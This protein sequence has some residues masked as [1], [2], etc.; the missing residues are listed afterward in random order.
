MGKK[1][2]YPSSSSHLQ[3]EAQRPSPSNER[4]SDPVRQDPRTGVHGEKMQH[5]SRAVYGNQHAFFDLEKQPSAVATTSKKP[6]SRAEALDI[7]QKD[8]VTKASIEKIQSLSK[9][10]YGSR[11]A[12]QAELEKIIKNPAR[13]ERILET[14]I[15]NP[16]SSHRM[17]GF[18]FRNFRTKAR[19]QAVQI[20]PHLCSAINVY[21]GNVKYLYDDMGV[22]FPME[23]SMEERRQRELFGVKKQKPPLSPERITC[24]AQ[25]DE[26]VKRYHTRVEH[27][28]NIVYGNP[29]A[30]QRQ[31]E[32][33][34]RNPTLGEQIAQIIVENPKSVH[35][36]AGYSICGLKS[37]TRLHAENCIDHLCNALANYTCAVKQAKESAVKQYEV[38]QKPPRRS[39]I[40]KQ[41][42]TQEHQR[43]QER[44]HISQH[45]VQ[46]PIGKT[47]KKV[48]FAM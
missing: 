46:Q 23:M 29:N 8:P 24:L 21:A 15:D 26:D 12:L 35:K 11:Y 48:A 31:M 43:T 42:M 16:Q 32:S 6:L 1:H 13:K 17:A 20:F 7:I 28:S 14:L 44:Q 38:P 40:Q 33:I 22:D 25:C 37:D 3:E 34:L 5:W 18:E 45:G 27:W 36:V 19:K 47:A 30:L 39:K 2:H 4:S 10:V 41:E 9:T